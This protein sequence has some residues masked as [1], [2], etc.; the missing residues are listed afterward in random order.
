MISFHAPVVGTVLLIAAVLTGWYSR[1]L[2]RR[3]S[4]ISKTPT[5]DLGQL[6]EAPIVEVQAEV[7]DGETFDSPIGNKECVLSVW[8]VD[9]YDDTGWE[10]RVSGIDA[11]PFILMMERGRLGSILR[12][13]SKRNLIRNGK[14]I[15]RTRH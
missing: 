7:I 11:R 12:I 6:S 13:M 10:T 15:G 3:Q 8:E 4:I 1:R 9:E 5:T 2:H 14:S